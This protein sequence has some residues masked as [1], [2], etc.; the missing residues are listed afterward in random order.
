MTTKGDHAMNKLPALTRHPHR[1]RGAL[2]AAALALGSW[3]L[4]GAAP[5]SAAAKG[6]VISTMK[7]TTW[8]T[9]LVSGRTLYTLKP[10][11]TACTASCLKYWPEVLL[12]KGVTKPLAGKGVTASK[13]GT[14]KRRGGRLQVTYEHKPLYWFALDTAPGQVKGNVTDTWGVWSVVVT[15]KPAVATTTTTVPRGTTT[16]VHTTTTTGPGS[17]TTT[18]PP[19]STTTVRPTTTT[20]APII[21]GGGGF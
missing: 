5:S 15:V 2:V 19:T 4:V 9:I 20:T 6:V 7:T 3:A 12:P 18:K 10:S 1:T 11:A 21:G 17:T 8:G 14:L 16:T 13:L